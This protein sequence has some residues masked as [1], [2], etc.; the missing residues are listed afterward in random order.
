M[1]IKSRNKSKDTLYPI[2]HIDNLK[3]L[4]NSSAMLYGEKPVF[5]KKDKPAGKFIP[6]KYEQFKDDINALGTALL[7]KNMKNKKIVV[8]GENR[9]EWILSYLAVVNGVGV[10]I[11]L[12]RE[13]PQRDIEKF[14]NMSEAN[15]IIYSDK[16]KKTI[17]DVRL[18]T[19]T[20]DCV[21]NMDSE[22]NEGDTYSLKKLIE[23]GYRL[24]ENNNRQYIDIEIDNEETKII[25]FTSGTTGNSKGVMLSHKNICANIM[26]TSKYVEITTEDRVLSVLP[27]HH[28]YECSCGILIPIYRGACVAFCEGLKYIVKNMQEAKIT[29]MIGVPLIFESM[30]TKIWRKA[31]KEGKAGKLK[32]GIAINKNLRKIGIDKGKKLFKS[33]HEALGGNVRLLISGAAAIDPEIVEC[34]NDMGVRMIQGYGMT[35][36]SPIITVNKDVYSKHGSAGLPLQGTEIKILEAN[37]EGIGEILCKSDSVMKGYYENEEETKKVFLDGWLR[38]GDY[39]YIDEDGFLFITG[40]K[41]NVI[42]T[43]NGKNIFPEEIEFYL[44]KNVYIKESIVFGKQDEQDSDIVVSCKVVVDNEYLEEIESN[45]TEDEVHNRIK[46]A[47]EE[48]NSNMT[49]Y[50]RVKRIEIIDSFEKTTTQKIKRFGKN[51][52]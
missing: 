29:I 46:N 8:I 5:L 22:E 30:Y 9:Y 15:V 47:I 11:P 24:I 2:R 37:E 39:G 4:V 52:V 48:V 10:I 49:P 28:T 26:N 16:I 33:V 38:T 43:K 17:D 12:D 27:I 23:E 42:V 45:L 18:N 50:K 34:F 40:R 19:K 7:N 41:K 51:M 13:L 44:N 1:K 36:C 35:E 3:S 21:I 14:V 20:I 32:K 31:E 6:V 25:L